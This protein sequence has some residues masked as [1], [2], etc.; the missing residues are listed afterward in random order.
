MKKILLVALTLMIGLSTINSAQAEEQEINVSSKQ[1][2]LYNVQTKEVLYSKNADDPISIYGLAKLMTLYIALEKI[3]EGEISLSDELVISQNASFT[4]GMEMFLEYDYKYTLED[5]IKGVTVLQANDATVALAEYLGD[6]KVSN[7]VE[8]MNDKADQLGMSNTKFTSPYGGYNS[9][10]TS[11]ANDLLKLTESYVTNFS[12]FLSFSKLEQHTAKTRLNDITQ[13][14][15]NSLLTSY[16]LTTGLMSDYQAP[17]ANG[18]FTAN[19]DGLQMIAI[20]L[21]SNNVSKRNYDAITLFKYGFKLYQAVT[22][23]SKNEEVTELKVYKSTK[24]KTKVVLASD[25]KFVVNVNDEANLEVDY[26]IPKQ[27]LG[28]K[29]KGDIVG[30]QIV[31]LNGEVLNEVDLKLNEDLPKGDLWWGTIRYG[32]R[33]VFNKITDLF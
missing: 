33:L 10:N 31:T 8:M 15:Q 26:D 6:G 19:N 25:A 23:G 29:E 9:Q 11:T 30:K 22:K 13:P 12:E 20:T 24:N 4:G 28:G 17:N 21:G 14:N 7:F 5:V 16:S 27:L 32:M 1:S 2:L 18:I 3:D